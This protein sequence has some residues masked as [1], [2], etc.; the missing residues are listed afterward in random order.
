MI[1]LGVG[2]GGW[3]GGCEDA[4]FQGWPQPASVFRDGSQ[5]MQV[6]HIGVAKQQ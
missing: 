1:C 2:G 4:V 5:L 6:G 3:E